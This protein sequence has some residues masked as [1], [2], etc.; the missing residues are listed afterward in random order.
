MRTKLRWFLTVSN[1]FGV[2]ILLALFGIALGQPSEQ[3]AGTRR[4]PLNVNG[5]LILGSRI[6]TGTITSQRRHGHPIG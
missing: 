3:Q 5:R 4:N 2:I 6:T 1:V